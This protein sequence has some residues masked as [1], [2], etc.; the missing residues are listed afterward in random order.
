MRTSRRTAD[1]LALC[2]CVLFFVIGVLW[3]SQLGFQQDE[4]LFA[5]GIY[6]P[7]ARENSVRAFKHE[8]PLMLMTYVG[9]LKAMVYR[10]LVFPFFEPSP[11]SVRVPVLLIGAASIWNFYRVLLR[12]FGKRAALAGAALLATDTSYMLTI[13]WDWGPVAL[14]H[15]CLISGVAAL[16]R[17]WDNRRPAVLAL[18]FFIFGLAM[19]DKALFIWSLAAL[20]ITALVIMPG[21]V[22][23]LLRPRNAA[24][25]SVAFL[26]GALP[27]VI[28]NVRHAGIT[29][30]GNARYSNEILGY[31][32]DL[33]WRTLDGSALFGFVVREDWEG[34]PRRPASAPEHALL[35]LNAAAKGPRTTLFGFAV[36]AALL[37]APFAR[38][39]RRPILFAIVFSVVLWLQMAFTHEAGTGMHHTVLLWPAPHFIIAG[40]IGALLHHRPRAAGFAAVA[41]AAL[42]VSNLLVTSTYYANMIRN[43]GAVGFSEAL[44]PAAESLKGDTPRSMCVIDWGFFEPIR[45]LHKG[46]TR[47]CIANVPS[48]V[49]ELKYQRNLLQ[50]PDVTF[51]AHVEGAEYYAGSLKRFLNF[52][53]DQGFPARN[54]RIFNDRNGRPIIQ[55]FQTSTR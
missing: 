39:H 41:V 45:L 22:R 15:L 55:T 23:E 29:F 34:P 32:A 17:Y 19:W 36:L 1:A 27:L 35:A 7:F 9:T 4:V 11:A 47:L 12:L 42:C 31:K 50:N 52:A 54:V 10:T 5:G 2:L 13:R 51:I 20:S 37:A 6:P 48:N 49:E 53:S 24:V 30:A 33:L 28:Y 16:V 21:F 3:I 40:V 8:F 25:A 46:E 14:Q 44:W 38:P 43:G 18:A 26:T